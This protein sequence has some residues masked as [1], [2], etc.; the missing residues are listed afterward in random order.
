MAI[1]PICSIDGCDKHVHAKGWCAKHYSRV[2]HHGDPY[3]VKGTVPGSGYS[4]LINVAYQYDGDDCL[5]WPFGKHSEGYGRIQIN[6][7]TIGAHR[8][9]CQNRHGPPPS[10]DMQA[11]HSCGNT[12]CCNPSHLR[13]ATP[14]ENTLDKV[15]HGTMLCGE[16]NGKAK[17]TNKQ[18]LDIR[19]IGKSRKYQDTA[20]QFNVSYATIES[21]ML[22]RSWRSVQE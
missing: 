11:A 14:K 1:K 3:S 13:W 12:S 17:L 9:V 15:K 20:D 18:V 4:F 7:K 8:L 5:I 19:Q 22:G 6:R 16:K 10:P 21:I 2:H